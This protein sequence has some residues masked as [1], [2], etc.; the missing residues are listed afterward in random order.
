[1]EE[2]MINKFKTY[3]DNFDF[4]NDMISRKFYHTF[5]VID[6]AKAIAKNENLDEH[7]TNLAFLCA[8]LHDIGRFE[9]ARVYKTYNDQ[10]SI[11]HGDLG[12]KILLKND[13]ISEF[14]TDDTD[15]QIVLKSVKNHNK[16]IADS[17]LTEKEAYFTKLVRDADKLDILDKQRLQ[18]TDNINTI[19]ENAISFIREHKL[20]KRNG[21]LKNDATEIVHSLSFIFDL[22]FDE[23]LKIIKEKKMIEHK[24]D[25]LEEQCNPIIVNELKTEIYNY[26]NN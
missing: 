13:F 4:S 7:E 6:Y 1:M 16:Y 22:N 25:V 18:I 2:I 9:Q 24:L 12:Y 19:D 20:F 10:L 8:L 21:A 14:V 11:D 3:V 15:K 26:L 23:S 5:R 17:S